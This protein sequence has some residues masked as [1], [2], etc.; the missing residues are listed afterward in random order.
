MGPW[1]LRDPEEA[2]LGWTSV[3]WEMNEC[4]R[5]FYVGSKKAPATAQETSQEERL[6]GRGSPRPL[7]SR[8]QERG[9]TPG[10]LHTL[11][12]IIPRE[13]LETLIIVSS[14]PRC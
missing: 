14:T 4:G 5:K 7:A 1:C 13:H 12:A 6:L 3:L 2:T 8:R 10:V 11:H 9:F